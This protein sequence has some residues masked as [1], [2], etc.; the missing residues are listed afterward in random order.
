MAGTPTVYVICDNNCKF[1]G[2]TKEQILTAISQAVESGEIK[3]VDAGFI[4]TIKTING[5]PLKFFVGDQSAYDA[6]TD[7]EKNNLFALITNDATKEGF[8]EAIEYLKS[9]VET[10]EKWKESLGVA[11]ETSA[12]FMSAQDKKNLLETLPWE[13]VDGE[14]NGKALPRVGWYYG[15]ICDA[16]GEFYSIP[17]FYWN[18]TTQN[19]AACFPYT[20]NVTNEGVCT[21]YENNTHKPIEITGAQ[22]YYYRGVKIA[23]NVELYLRAIKYKEA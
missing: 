18:K 16:N 12:G 4:S 9:S 2:M 7:D 5:V 10:L 19:Y 15:A 6:L 3:D 14:S 17:P 22:N 21:V 11:T 20:L 8:I 1:E 23:S 13:F